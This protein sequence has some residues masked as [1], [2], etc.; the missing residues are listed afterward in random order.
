[1]S[2]LPPLTILLGPHTGLS[3][4]LNTIVRTERAALVAAGLDAMPSRIASPMLRR[5]LNDR[6]AEE[7]AAE[8]AKATANRPVFLSA[9]NFFGPPQ[10]G[11][12]QREMFPNVEKSLAALA[13]IAPRA[14]LVMCVD[15]LPAL[16]LA[17]GSEPLEARVLRT[18]WEVLYE[19]SWAELAQEI[20]V[21]LP[22][23]ELIVLTPESSGRNARTTLH[24]LFGTAAM[25]MSDPNAL[26]R[27]V[28]TETGHAVLDRLVAEGDASDAMLAELHASF[29]RRPTQMECNQRLGIDKVTFALL[30]QRFAEDL[31]AIHA[32]PGTRVL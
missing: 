4:G 12:L 18:P 25:T 3:L 23:A 8:F 22:D 15:A 11:M 7:R 9:L 14:R 6:P 28:I 30:E 10:A 24:R 17:A 27:S 16:F 31:A 19:L 20:K 5:C 32:L 1:M 29:A 26:L 2:D 13:E 21:A